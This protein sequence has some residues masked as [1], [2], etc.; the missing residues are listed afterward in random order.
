MEETLK[1]LS[2]PGF[3]FG[4][5]IVGILVNFASQWMYGRLAAVPRFL[6]TWAGNRTKAR[7]E[8]HDFDKALLLRSPELIPIYTGYM[9]VMFLMA[10]TCA[11][12]FMLFTLAPSAARLTSAAI[13][14]G[15][16]IKW[17]IVSAM[18]L[19]MAGIIASSI[20]AMDRVLA[21]LN[22][23][24]SVYRTIAMRTEAKLLEAEEQA[25]GPQPPAQDAQNDPGIGAKG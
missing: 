12:I 22:V 21:R 7:R 15:I 8:Q 9:L 24:N 20:A 3:W 1:L 4:S 14:E 19:S 13:D 16:S 10:I 17:L 18:W 11:L 6:A 5:V 23:L 2:T 25:L